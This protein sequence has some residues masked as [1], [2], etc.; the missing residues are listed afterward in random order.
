MTIAASIIV[1]RFTFITM[2]PGESQ[3]PTR[4]QC[5]CNDRANGYDP[6][7]NDRWLSYQH[8]QPPKLQ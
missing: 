3:Q 6:A 2:S 7:Q 4:H 8:I 1:N 5:K